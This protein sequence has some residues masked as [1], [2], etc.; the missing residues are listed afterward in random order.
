MDLNRLLAMRLKE[1][2]YQ[3]SNT[4]A[5]KIFK[6]KSYYIDILCYVLMVKGWNQTNSSKFRPHIG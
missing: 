3:I 6:D 5:K 2:N 1:E 4:G